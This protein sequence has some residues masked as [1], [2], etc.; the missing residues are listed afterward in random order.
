MWNI[1]QKTVKLTIYDNTN[2]LI[3]SEKLLK[4]FVDDLLKV[5]YIQTDS[6]KLLI[7]EKRIDVGVGFELKVETLWSNDN[8]DPNWYSHHL[9]SFKDFRGD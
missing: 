3:F 6:V 2:K 1:K 5:D 8:T 7:K 4:D 9:E